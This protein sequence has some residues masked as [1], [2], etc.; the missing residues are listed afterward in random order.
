MW[1]LIGFILIC[2]FFLVF[3]AL[4]L[5]NASDVSLGFRTF[6]GIPVFLIAFS[7]F[8]FG[9]LFAIPFVLLFGRRRKKA[10]HPAADYD[11]AGAVKPPVPAKKSWGFPKKKKDAAAD[12]VPELLPAADEIKKE[13]SPYG[14]D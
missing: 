10:S 13:Q 4:N 11:S 1:R 7:S 6:T 5:E 2:A 3:V 12:A 8:V 14:V 9:M